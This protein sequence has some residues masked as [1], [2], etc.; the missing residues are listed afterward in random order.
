MKKFLLLSLALLALAAPGWAETYSV[1]TK[2][3]LVNAVNDANGKPATADNPHVITVADGTYKLNTTLLLSKD[4]T[5]K[6]AEGATPVL[7]RGLSDDE[8]APDGSVITC[9]TN[10][11]H[12]TLQG[13][14]LTGGKVKHN[15]FFIGV[16]GVTENNHS[17][18]GGVFFQSNGALTVS[19]CTFTGNV[20][21]EGNTESRGGGMF[22]GGGTVKVSHCI[23]TSNH[24]DKNGGGMWVESSDVT[25]TNCRFTGNHAGESG[26]FRNTEN[27]RH[28][29]PVR[30][31]PG[32]AGIFFL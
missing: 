20:A 7:D 29:L 18:G 12:I 5:L 4:I 6:A 3:E 24:A 19:D 13:L 15:F 11:V 14:T 23:F 22:V 28:R 21:T 17:L 10:G 2:E 26:L 1:A 25:V 32:Q 31:Q 27:V 8:A 16:D 30:G 9:R